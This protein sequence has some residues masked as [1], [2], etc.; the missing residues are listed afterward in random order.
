MEETSKKE[1]KLY[2]IGIA[3]LCLA[4]IGCYA[5]FNKKRKVTVKAIEKATKIAE[6]VEIS[7]Y[8]R[9][10]IDVFKSVDEL[11]ETWFKQNGPEVFK[12]VE[13]FADTLNLVDG[14][15]YI[16]EKSAEFGTVVSHIFNGFGVYPEMEKLFI[17]K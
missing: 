9:A 5:Y 4:G 1:T 13:A 12:Q 17:K 10:M 7:K 2:A 15:S 8:R 16:I 11:A 14:E 3:G 6:E